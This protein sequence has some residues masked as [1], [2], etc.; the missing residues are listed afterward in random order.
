MRVHI[1]H[2]TC[3]Y[4]GSTHMQHVCVSFLYWNIYSSCPWWATRIACLQGEALNSASI[5]R[6]VV[7]ECLQWHPD[8][9]IVAIGWQSG[10]ITTYSDTDHE[11]FEQSSIHRAAIG[12][13][14]WNKAGSKLV[15]GDKVRWKFCAGILCNQAVTGTRLLVVFVHWFDNPIASL[16]SIWLLI[17]MS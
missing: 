4:P 5:H 6:S 12:F 15:S 7:A 2:S 9:K 3:T 1:V 13:L 11:I 8:K 10:E 16:W 14:Q 17:K